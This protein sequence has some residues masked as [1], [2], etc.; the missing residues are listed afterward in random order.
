MAGWYDAGVVTKAELE[1]I[2]QVYAMGVICPAEL[3]GTIE[4]AV[5]A[6]ELKALLNEID[7]RAQAVLREV[8]YERPL[9]RL[10]LRRNR[11]FVLALRE[12]ITSTSA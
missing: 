11:P 1:R 10:V 4:S 3:W 12:W 8:Y 7:E 6:T 2:V 9:S 5:A